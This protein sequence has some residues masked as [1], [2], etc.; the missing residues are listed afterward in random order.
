MKLF[1]LKTLAE[2]VAEKASL[3]GHLGG[4]LTGLIGGLVIAGGHGKSSDGWEFFA[5][6]GLVTEVKIWT[7]PNGSVEEWK[8]YQRTGKAFGKSA[9]DERV[10]S[11]KPAGARIIP[12][13]LE[14]LW[15][16]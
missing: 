4:W 2:R 13:G 5:L 3:R 10:A 14:L 1:V 9:H 12:H 8:E 7:L 6:S 15:W 16:F 11:L